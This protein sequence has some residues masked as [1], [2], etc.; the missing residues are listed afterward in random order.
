MLNQHSLWGSNPIQIGASKE[1][2]IIEE[3]RRGEHAVVKSP[4]ARPVATSL[5][6]FPMPTEHTAEIQSGKVRRG[7]SSGCPL[8]DEGERSSS[9]LNLIMSYN[10]G[11]HIHAIYKGKKQCFSFIPAPAR[12]FP[13]RIAG[14]GKGARCLRSGGRKMSPRQRRK[15]ALQSARGK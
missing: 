7:P 13:V 9:F 8:S 2:I 12:Q 5:A 4:Q 10:V 14:Y 6:S 11:S 15:S 1:L 3:G